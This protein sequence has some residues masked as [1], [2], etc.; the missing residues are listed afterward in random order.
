MLE[1]LKDIATALIFAG[2]CA[3]GAWQLRTRKQ[4]ILAITEDLIQKAELAICGSGLG[5]EKKALVVAQLEAMGIHATA[6]LDKEI[7]SIVAWLNTKSAWYADSA[8]DT[9]RCASESV[10]GRLR[11]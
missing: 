2:V 4:Q 9:I 3:I 10:S 1:I 11:S 6:W 8:N 5:A 7:D